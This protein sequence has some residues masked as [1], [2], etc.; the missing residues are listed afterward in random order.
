MR[1]PDDSA[2]YTLERLTERAARLIPV[3]RERAIETSKQRQ[4]P[5]KTVADLWDADLFH[6]LKPKNSAGR[7]CAPTSRSR[8]PISSGAATARPR[9][10][11]Q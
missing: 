10:S 2:A 3:L 6:L 8:W 7:R 5:D 4:L 11:G 1:A 9:G